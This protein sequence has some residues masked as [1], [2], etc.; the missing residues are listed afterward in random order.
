MI[1]LVD[2][3]K[4]DGTFPEEPARTALELADESEVVE[5]LADHG[6]AAYVRRLFDPY[7]F[8]WVNRSLCRPEEP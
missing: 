3:L 8:L 4:G 2:L 5:W 6:S 1:F 7:G